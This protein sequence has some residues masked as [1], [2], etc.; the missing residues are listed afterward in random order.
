MVKDP[1]IPDGFSAESEADVP[2]V[3]LGSVECIPASGL[4][5]LTT[6][7]AQAN[8]S[9]TIPEIVVQSGTAA[10]NSYVDFLLAEYPNENTRRA[11]K[12]QLDRFLGWCGTYDWDPAAARVLAGITPRM[13]AA[14]RDRVRGSA[15]D[16]K[17]RLAALRKFFDL[18]VERHICLINP[19]RSTRNPKEQL[20]EGKTTEIPAKEVERLIEA[21]D[22]TTLIG[23]RDRAV[24]AAWAATGVRVGAVSKLRIRNFFYHDGQW[25]LELDEKNAKQRVV[26]VRHDLQK[27]I[28]KYLSEAQLIGAGE[29][30]HLFRT[31]AGRTGLLRPYEPETYAEDGT[32]L[33]GAR[34]AMTAD[35]MRRMLK[36]R[37]TDA[38]FGKRITCKTPGV[39]EKGRHHTY[40]RYD[41]RY[42]PHS[43][44]VMV[45][46]DLLDQGNDIDDVAFLV[47]HSS[48]R[49]TQGY[50]RNKRK[51]KRN[52]VERIRVNLEPEP[53][54]TGSDDSAVDG[55]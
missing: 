36:R 39:D 13:C 32:I 41:A 19:A 25:F 2:S 26:P 35:D 45:V 27:C 6:E 21:V 16:K 23:L 28:L 11:Y 1:Q 40:T 30:G 47:G 43:F 3:R 33:E 48:T 46:T 22:A 53:A 8:V 51:V 34:G 42:S 49:T 20:E 44:R 24:I 18:L 9:S 7:L 52:L 12:R 5:R 37:L 31:A 55:E 15:S 50:N 38:G 10:A 17:Q 4:Q 29:D 54:D 14:F